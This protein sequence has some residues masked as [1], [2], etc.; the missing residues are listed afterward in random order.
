[1]HRRNF[2]RAAG[3]GV[4]ILPA[5][6]AASAPLIDTH[7][8]FYDP[9]RPRGVP[10]PPKNDALLYKTVLPASYANLV[11]PLGVTGAIVIE[12]SAWLED[13]QWVLDLARESR[14]IAGVVG[15][16]EPGNRGFRKSLERFARNPLFRGIRLNGDAIAGGVVRPAFLDDIRHLA[17][18]GLMMDAIGPASMLRPLLALTARVPALRVGIDHMPGEPDGWQTG[19]GSRAMMRELA[20]RP[21]VFCKVSGV[22]PRV[23]G[24][25][26][27]DELW[28]MFGPARVMYGS[29]WPVSDRVAPYADILRTVKEYAESRGPDA[30][31]G[32]FAGNA[33]ACYRIAV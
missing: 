13:N 21:Q 12:A 28:E 6:H 14:M 1:M 30:A 22:R 23:D 9:A 33:K 19:A 20:Q 11:Q 29:N 17:G 18:A 24:A 26:A 8:H 2:L 15:H 16:L 10:W 32:F 7:V 3:G 31:A 25:P 27:L 5:L 4:L